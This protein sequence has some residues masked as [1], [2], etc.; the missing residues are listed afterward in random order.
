MF[1]KALVVYLQKVSSDYT[2]I[3]TNLIGDHWKRRGDF[4]YDHRW[5]SRDGFRETM[6]GKWKHQEVDRVSLGQ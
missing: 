3:I 2:P 4:K 1:S 6:L 5:M